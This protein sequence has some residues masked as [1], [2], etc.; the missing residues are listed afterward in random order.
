V[1]RLS[2]DLQEGTIVMVG[3]RA[4]PDPALSELPRV[5]HLGQFAFEQLPAL[6]REA[7]VLIMPYAD[8]PV[9]RAMQ[10]LKLKEYLAT[11]KPTVVRDLP[12]VRPW[13]DCLDCVDTAEAFSQMVRRRA[14]EGV[15]MEQQRQRARLAEESWAAKAAE[16]ERWALHRE[17]SAHAACCS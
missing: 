11:G 9:T 13:A 14:H 6:A 2:A 7:A 16:F 15:P 1:R 5:V 3:P 4:D 17:S 10:P 12:A 8:L